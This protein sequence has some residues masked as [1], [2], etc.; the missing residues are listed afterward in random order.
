MINNS[1]VFITLESQS[2]NVSVDSDISTMVESR[3]SKKQ[4]GEQVLF[5]CFV[6]GGCLIVKSVF[7]TAE[8]YLSLYEQQQ[9]LLGIRNFSVFAVVLTRVE[10]ETK[11]SRIDQIN[12]FTGCLPQFLLGPFLITLSHIM[13]YVIRLLVRKFKA[14]SLAYSS[15]ALSYNS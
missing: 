5:S 14:K 10:Y 3:G 12:V 15:V 6:S 11:Y 2:K 4:P 13:E 9:N 7:L 1:Q 8:F